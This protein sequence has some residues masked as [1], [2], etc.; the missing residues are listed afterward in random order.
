MNPQAI[1]T[2]PRT[3][4]GRA[5]NVTPPLRPENPLIENSVGC[6]PMRVRDYTERIEKE[7]AGLQEDLTRLRAALTS[8]LPEKDAE[9]GGPPCTVD[10]TA[11]P[12]IHTL[13]GIHQRLDVT[14]TFVNRLTYNIQ[15]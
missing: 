7:I 3:W 14:R 13:A 4:P 5:Q 2:D 15:L 10:P 9:I 8:V 11:G 6:E 12:L 1:N